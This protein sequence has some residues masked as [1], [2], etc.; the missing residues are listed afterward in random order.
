LVTKAFTARRVE[1][2]RPRAQQIADSLVDAMLAQGAPADL[3]EDFA[4]LLPITV[5]CELL[6]VPVEDRTDFRVWSDAFLSTSKFTVDEVIV[7]RGQLRAYIAALIAARRDDPRDD[8]LTA[9]VS[10]RDDDDRL[11]EEELLSLSEAILIAGH[12]TT[13]SQIPNFVHTL[14]VHPDQLAVLGADLDL[15]PRAVEELLRFT[16]LGEGGTQ[17]RYALE[18]VELGGITVRAGEPVVVAIHAANRDETVYTRPDELDLHRR[19]ASHIG[20]G[21]GPHHCL[22]A[23]LARMELQV[24]LRTLLGRLPGLRHAGEVTWK[25]GLSTRGPEHMPITWEQS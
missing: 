4:L 12:E 8:L 18:D 22:G 21:H 14:L 5:I 13:A 24:A 15:V 6:G 1:A 25:S 10:A 20:F 3:V 11:S 16:P 9:L 17:A 7:H 2:L 23:S 19:E